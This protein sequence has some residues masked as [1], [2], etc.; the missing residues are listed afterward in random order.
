MP[1]AMFACHHLYLGHRRRVDLFLAVR[2]SKV[3]ADLSR[4][5]LKNNARHPPRKEAS[6]YGMYKPVHQVF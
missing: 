6:H 3:T 1:P 4:G 5:F 2:M